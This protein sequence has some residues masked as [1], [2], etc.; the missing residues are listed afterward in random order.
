MLKYNGSNPS[1]LKISELDRQIS[2]KQFCVSFIFLQTVLVYF[3]AEFDSN[4]RQGRFMAV[5]SSVQNDTN[6]WKSVVV[7]IFG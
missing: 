3:D 5:K 6:E 1:L 7:S 2:L 4:Y